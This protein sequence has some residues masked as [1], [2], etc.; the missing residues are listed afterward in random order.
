MHVKTALKVTLTGLLGLLMVGCANNKIKTTYV[1]EN[2]GLAK[3][4]SV[5][6]YDFTV[7]PQAVKKSSSPLSGIIG[8]NENA[9]EEKNKLIAEV[10]DAMS[11]ELVKKITELGLNPKRA[12]QTT[13]VTPGALLITGQITNI[14]EGSNIK[15]NVIGFGAGQSSLD[16]NVVV[17]APV[18]SGNK[19]LISFDAHGDSGEKPGALVLGPVGAAAGAGTAATV[20]A[21]AAQGVA[22]SYKSASAHQAEDM[23]EKINTQLAKYFSKQGWISADLAK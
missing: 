22:S 15:R 14:D 16:A 6:V 8:S 2:S 11:K 18:A 13:T 19:E 17:M 4:T 3:P 1:D 23:A 9:A 20:A 5:L 12:D 7:D 10:V 21:N